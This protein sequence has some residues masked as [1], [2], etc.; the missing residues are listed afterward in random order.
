MYGGFRKQDGNYGGNFS[1]EGENSINEINN[2][3][4]GRVESYEVA[5]VP[6]VAP[7]YRLQEDDTVPMVSAVVHSI[8][9]APTKRP[10]IVLLDSGS[11]VSWWNGKSLPKGCVPKKGER[12]KSLTL[13]GEMDSSLT[14]QLQGLSFPEFFKKRTMDLEC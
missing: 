1:E 13:A 8:N 12:M 10:F 2:V 14:V 5:P 6:N 9:K 3:P 4:K 11:G 7:G